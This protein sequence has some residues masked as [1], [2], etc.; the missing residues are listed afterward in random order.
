[1][2]RQ[3]GFSPKVIADLIASIVAFLVL[4]VALGLDPVLAAALSKFVGTLGGIWA[5]PGD[6][7]TTNPS[8]EPGDHALRP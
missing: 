4:A 6:V 1:M 3:I 5:G 2:T 8:V 7:V